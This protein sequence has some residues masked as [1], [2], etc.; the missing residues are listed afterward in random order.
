MYREIGLTVIENR[1]YVLGGEKNEKYEGLIRGGFGIP[2]TI[3][4]PDRPAEERFVDLL[5][6]MIKDGLSDAGAGV[7]V[8]SMPRGSSVADA[9]KKMAA[10]KPGRYVVMVVNDSN[11]D[12]GGLNFRYVYDFVVYVT[13]PSGETIG[14]KRFTG[15]QANAPSDKHNVFDMHSVIYRQLIESMFSEPVIR[16][17]LS[18]DGRP[19]AG[20]ATRPGASQGPVNIEDLKGLLPA[21]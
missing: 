4:R 2:V 13:S 7:T 10:A 11:W 6:A 18:G 21:R 20:E 9:V 17:A 15:T 8:T 1:R 12:A 5:S 16:N 19:A 3:D 14:V